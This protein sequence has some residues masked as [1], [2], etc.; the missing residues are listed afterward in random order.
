MSITEAQKVWEDAK[1]QHREFVKAKSKTYIRIWTAAEEIGNKPPPL[2]LEAVRRAYEVGFLT[3][4]P[5]P[6]NEEEAEG[7]KNPPASFGVELPKE[8][9]QRR[10][11]RKLGREK[12]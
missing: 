7:K 9:P 12:E 5:F 8:H 1:E 11:S 6:P 10:L 4:Q 2:D 3:A